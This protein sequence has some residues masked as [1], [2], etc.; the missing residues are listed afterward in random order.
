MRRY[1]T[2]DLADCL[3]TY[4]RTFREPKE[5]VL[6]FNW[7]GSTVECI[8]S[9]TQLTVTFRA[10]CGYEVEGMP[11]DPT[12][13]RRATWPWVGVFLDDMSMPIRKFQISSPAETWLLYQSAA[14]ETHRIRLTKLTENGKTF[15][16]I[17]AFTAEGTFLPAQKQRRRRMEIVGDSIACGYGNLVK[18]PNRHFFSADEDGWQAYGPMAARR[19]GMEYSCVSIS[20][21][22]A[23][24]HPGWHG[25]YAMCELYAYT[26]K[27]WQAKLQMEPQL[28]DFEQNH[29]DYVVVNLGTNDCYA[30]LFCPEAEEL[31]RF[32]AAYITF[33]EEIRRA[34]G[35]DTQI[36]CAL[37]PMNYYLFH[38]IANAV[39][40]YCQRTGDRNVHLLRLRP[41]RPFDG[42]G[43]DGHP[44]LDTH[45]KMAQEL[46]DFILSLEKQ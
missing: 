38:D 5:D 6:Y 44:S 41:M 2:S 14:P 19:L 1:S 34:N 35:A 36:I 25:D 10:E 20:G 28:W 29:N 4:G 26:D 45:R 30:I 32:Q 9:G 18:D 40:L 43:A 31:E 27:V 11:D 17:S 7:S 42:V 22:T 13:P 24:K 15:L 21:I 23:V 12:A 3:V 8:F 33:L 37:G 16:G 39:R 46:V